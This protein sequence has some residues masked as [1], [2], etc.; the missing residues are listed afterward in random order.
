MLYVMANLLLLSIINDLID[1][2]G[3]TFFSGFL[4]NFINCIVA[5]AV[6]AV[7][8]QPG[9]RVAPRCTPQSSGRVFL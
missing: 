1:T 6:F 4:L 8:I 9:E 7:A 3:I 5:G 2:H